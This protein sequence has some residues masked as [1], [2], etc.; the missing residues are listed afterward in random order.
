MIKKNWEN[1]NI[2]TGSLSQNVSSISCLSLNCSDGIA[3]YHVKLLTETTGSCASC[4]WWYSAISS[5]TF[6]I[7]LIFSS[8]VALISLFKTCI[9]S[10]MLAIFF[11]FEGVWGDILTNSRDFLHYS[12][13]FLSRRSLLLFYNPSFQSYFALLGAPAPCT[14]LR[15]LDL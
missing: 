13:P 1:L 3:V 7:S 5:E 12:L 2:F 4:Q 15:R 6:I 14:S 10:C 9:F 11:G 8:S